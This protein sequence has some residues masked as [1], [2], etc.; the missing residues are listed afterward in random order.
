MDYNLPMLAEKPF[1]GHGRSNEV[2]YLVVRRFMDLK[3]PLQ[4]NYWWARVVCHCMRSEL[5]PA[6][7]DIETVD[8]DLGSPLRGIDNIRSCLPHACSII[9]ELE[10]SIV[11]GSIRYAPNVNSGCAVLKFRCVSMEGSVASVTLRFYEESVAKRRGG[12]AVNGCTVNRALS[13]Q[14]GV[15]QFRIDHGRIVHLNPLREVVTSFIESWQPGIACDW[16]RVIHID[17]MR[18]K[19][20][21][22]CLDLGASSH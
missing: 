18:A 8:V 13:R 7:R 9:A 3:L 11:D 14:A 6:A 2:T 19:L 1:I 10:L 5:I 17:Q 22:A 12:F 4:V 15:E 21:E 20:E 16:W